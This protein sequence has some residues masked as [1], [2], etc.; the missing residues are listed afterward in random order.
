MAIVALLL[1]FM[2]NVPSYFFMHTDWIDFAKHTTDLDQHERDRIRRMLRALYKRFEGVFVLN[3]DHRD[4]L[5]GREMQLEAERVYLTAH[6]AQPRHPTASPI[7]KSELFSDASADT[8]ILFTACRLSPEKGI[9]ELPRILS[10]ARASLPDLRLVIAGTGP[11]EAELKAALP[12]ARFLGRV[13]RQRMAELYLGL[14]LFVSPSRFDTFGNVILEALAHGMP[15]VAY[16]CKGPKDILADGQSG[17]LVESIEE[18]GDRI[19]SHFQHPEAREAMRRSAMA[20]AALY[21]AEPIMNRFLHDLGLCDAP[22]DRAE[23]TGV[24]MD[25][26]LGFDDGFAPVRSVA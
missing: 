1:K 6:H 16:N 8:P 22:R 9:F 18:M 4:W 3:S 20:R 23:Q 19:V 17:Y 7:D 14:D 24:Q 2:F 21:Q 10:Q 12:E 5:T 13:D 11:A 25:A 26:N 15:A